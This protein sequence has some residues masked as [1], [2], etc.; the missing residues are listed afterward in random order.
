MKKTD[1]GDLL[2]LGLGVLGL[3]AGALGGVLEEPRQLGAGDGAVA[4]DVAHVESLGEL[5]LG[6]VRHGADEGCEF[7][8]LERF[9][10]FRL[11]LKSGGWNRRALVLLYSARL[12]NMHETQPTREAPTKRR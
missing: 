1:L 3:L 2:A 5:L 11:K 6:E 7:G 12:L 8:K 10:S 4:V 9:D